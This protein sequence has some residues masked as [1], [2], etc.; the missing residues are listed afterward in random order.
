[1]V[2]HP[3]NK[4]CFKIFYAAFIGLGWGCICEK[5]MERTGE[6]SFLIKIKLKFNILIIFIKNK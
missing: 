6:N 5:L 4:A 3:K 2:L 1:L